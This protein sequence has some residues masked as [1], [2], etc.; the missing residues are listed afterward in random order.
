M[1][2]LITCLVAWI[3]VSRRRFNE[4]EEE[5]QRL[6]SLLHRAARRIAGLEQ[7]IWDDKKKG[8]EPILRNLDLSVTE[9]YDLCADATIHHV[10]LRPLYYRFIV[11]RLQK[12]QCGEAFV[13]QMKRNA[14]DAIAVSLV[15]QMEEKG[16]FKQKE[17]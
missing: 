9:E 1:R 17:D 11:P 13:D 3:P 10:E 6:S 4:V 2:R 16:Y 8:L 15:R 14:I 7:Q 12:L 5:A